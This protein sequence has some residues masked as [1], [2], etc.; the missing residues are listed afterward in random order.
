MKKFIIEKNKYLNQSIKCYYNC[1]YIGYQQ[2]GNPDFI[3]KLKNMS[4]KY[5]EIDL[6]QDFIEVAERAQKDLKEIIISNN[7]SKPVVCIIPRSKAERHYAQSQLMFKKAISSIVK[8]IDVVDGSDFIKRTEDTKT[9][10]DW[11]L[12]HNNGALPYK[13]I[14]KDTC[15]FKK[16]AFNN[17]DV[18]LI[19]DIYTEGKNIAE[20]FIQSL[21][22]FGARNVILYVI[23][24]TR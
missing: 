3:N 12:K 22:D 14:S 20:D 23:A 7:L 17:E 13:G 18:I 15:S 2:H 6:V 21:F 19:D 4:K 1:D 10:H 16:Y 9:T 11:R 24:K 8:K 5:T